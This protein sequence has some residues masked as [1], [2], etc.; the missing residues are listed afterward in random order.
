MLSE[1]SC[2]DWIYA[3]KEP[4]VRYQYFANMSCAL[5]VSLDDAYTYLQSVPDYK[6]VFGNDSDDKEYFAEIFP[7]KSKSCE[8]VIK[9]FSEHFVSGKTVM[10]KLCPYSSKYSNQYEEEEA[11]LLLYLLK[12]QNNAFIENEEITSKYFRFTISVR[13]HLSDGTIG[14]CAPFNR[15][16]LTLSK[17]LRKKPTYKNSGFPVAEILQNMRTTTSML[18]DLYKGS[19]SEKMVVFNYLQ[20]TLSEYESRYG[21][22]TQ[23]QAVEAWNTLK[24]PVAYIPLK[25]QTFSNHTFSSNSSELSDASDSSDMCLGFLGVPKDEVIKVTSP[26]STATEQAED[27]LGIGDVFRLIQNNMPDDVNPDNECPQLEN[28]EPF[29]IPSDDLLDSL[30]QLALEDTPATPDITMIPDSSDESTEKNII[31]PELFMR[32]GYVDVSESVNKYQIIVIEKDD[33]MHAMRH[34]YRAPWIAIE[35]GVLGNEKGLCIYGGNNKVSC[36]IKDSFITPG[37]IQMLLHSTSLNVITQNLPMLYSISL[38][39]GNHTLLN[40]H[41]LTALYNA[42]T[43][44]DELYPYLRLHSETGIKIDNHAYTDLIYHL[45]LYNDFLSAME[46]KLEK[47]RNNKT[48]VNYFCYECMIGS[49]YDISDIVRMDALNLS[50]IDFKKNDFLYSPQNRKSDKATILKIK[51]DIYSDNSQANLKKQ[52]VFLTYILAYIQRETN[53]RHFHLRLLCALPGDFR[54]YT[55]TKNKE[56]LDILEEFISMIII[57]RAKEFNLKAPNIEIS[58]S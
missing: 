43:D 53:L 3:I 6:K 39:Y 16:F 19:F 8:R 21:N 57:N 26:V 33:I 22:I 37:I 36:F 50:R 17:K 40:V 9:D 20:E 29:D 34:I 51:Y 28:D 25:K 18:D 14:V 24:N 55:S 15:L 11:I 42:L 45:S 31:H 56:Q 41:S 2:I 38:A 13:D 48:Y 12:T 7:R 35:I 54:I 47:R 52:L 4:H 32:N 5:G 1:Y 46:C 23:K 30:N 58:Y 49:A 27:Y 44:S 10:C